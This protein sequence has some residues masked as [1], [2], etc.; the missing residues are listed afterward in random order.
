VRNQRRIILASCV[1]GLVLAGATGRHWWVWRHYYGV[2]ADIDAAIAEASVMIAELERARSATG[3]YP[4]ALPPAN[5]R[6]RATTIGP[7]EWRYV[8]AIGGQ[9]YELF[10]THSHWVSSF[11]A[12]VYSPDGLYDADWTS[13]RHRSRLGWLYVIGASDLEERW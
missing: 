13:L 3:R 12:L 2:L 4:G 11:N 8:P 7:G 9:D 10:C 5:G 6:A 1:V